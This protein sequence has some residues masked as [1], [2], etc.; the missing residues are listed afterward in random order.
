[1][2]TTVEASVRVVRLGPARSGPAM[3]LARA[4][5]SEAAVSLFSVGGTSSVEM[6]AG[7]GAARVRHLFARAVAGVD[8]TK[9]TAISE[10]PIRPASSLHPTQH[11]NTRRKP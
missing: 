7:V 9:E 10:M 8:T 4:V 2:S 11:N 6:F 1:M 3:V 5:A